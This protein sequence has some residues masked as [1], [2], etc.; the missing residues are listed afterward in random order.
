MSDFCQKLGKIR[1][2]LS[3]A[4][5]VIGPLRVNHNPA[6]IFCPENVVCITC[7]S[8]PEGDVKT[9]GDGDAQ[10]FQHLEKRDLCPRL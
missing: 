7:L 1:Q 8:S 9:L 3:S 10:G 5:I 4:A 2:N 6:N